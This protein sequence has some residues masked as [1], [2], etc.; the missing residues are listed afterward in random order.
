VTPEPGSAQVHVVTDSVSDIPDD[1][2]SRL[3]IGFVPVTVRFGIEQF[4]DRVEMSVRDFLRRL[5]TSTQVAKTSQPSPGEFATAFRE[6]AAGGHSVVSIQPSANLSGTYQAA[7]VARDVLVRQGLDIEVVD[8]RSGSMGQGWAAIEAARAALEGCT[9]AEVL[10]R[11][12]RVV[13]RVKLLITVDTLDYIHRNG[14]IGRAQALL[15]SLLHIKPI[16]TLTDGELDA[17]DKV[18]G[19][20]RVLGRLLHHLQR[21]VPEGARVRCAVM[22]ADAA[23]R[24]QQLAEALKRL[25]DVCELLITETG[26]AIAANVGP[27]AYGATLYEA[28]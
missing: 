14:R 8:S 2:L 25:F 11:V 6:A 12:A 21:M 20:E 1:M 19:A 3:K 27:G 5:R 7:C 28:T 24:A 13:S 17:V 26:P 10:S 4:K 15:G 9:K 23:E 18:P 16:L 22:H